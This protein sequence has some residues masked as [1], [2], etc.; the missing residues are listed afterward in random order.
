VTL[1]DDW[2]FDGPEAH[3]VGHIA[4]SANVHREAIKDERCVLLRTFQQDFLKKAL[5]AES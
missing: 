5:S 3:V 1:L 4:V 2:N